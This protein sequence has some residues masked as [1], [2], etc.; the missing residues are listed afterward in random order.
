MNRFS[1]P[2][3]PRRLASLDYGQRRRARRLA[4]AL[5]GVLVIGGIALF[6]YS[7]LRVLGVRL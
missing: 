4:Y 6:V 2:A 7:L 1:P 3:H 5:E